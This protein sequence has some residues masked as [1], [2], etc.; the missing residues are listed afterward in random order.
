MIMIMIVKAMKSLKLMMPILKLSKPIFP[1]IPQLK[2]KVT[3]NVYSKNLFKIKIKL[4]RKIILIILLL[5]VKTKFLR[6][7][8]F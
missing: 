8:R 2:I 6:I 7:T 5:I 3:I 1:I 4:F